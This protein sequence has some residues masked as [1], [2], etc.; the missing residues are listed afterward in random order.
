MKRIITLLLLVTVFIAAHAEWIELGES[1]DQT[2]YINPKIS[3]DGYSYHLAWVK[4]VP[5]PKA[6]AQERRTLAKDYKNSKY[7]KYTHRIILYKFDLSANK[8]K[9]ISTTTY[10]SERVIETSN[11]EY[12]SD[13]TYP[14]PDSVGEDILETV[15][16]IVGQKQESVAAPSRVQVPMRKQGTSAGDR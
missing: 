4:H 3:K 10:A 15:K 14:I 13:W 8:Y 5:K 2:I 16:K 12:L 9:D 7:L 1:V 11:Y 6:L